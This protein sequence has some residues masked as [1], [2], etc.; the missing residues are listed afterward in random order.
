[1]V[2]EDGKWSRRK[3]NRQFIVWVKRVVRRIWI[4]EKRISIDRKYE[5]N[6]PKVKTMN[7]K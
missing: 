4:T 1:M 2:R 5:R 6:H 7:A 3:W